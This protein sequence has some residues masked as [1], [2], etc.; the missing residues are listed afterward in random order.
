MGGHRPDAL[1]LGLRREQLRSWHRKPAL[2][3]VYRDYHRRL[4][5]L[6]P[7][8]RLL[9]VGA[10]I[11]H[12]RDSASE[13]KPVVSLDVVAIPGIDVNGDAHRLR[14]RDAVFDGIVM[15]DTLHHLERPARFLREAARVVRPGGRLVMIEPGLTPLS[16]RLFRSFHVEPIDLAVDPYASGPLSRRRAPF[17]ANQA[18]PTLMV[19]RNDAA[20][21]L[22]DVDSRLRLVHWEWLSLGRIH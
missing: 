18:I 7:Q 8:G 15:L 17:D 6:S 12:L 11:R 10:G 5:S 2:R 3:R 9:E 13:D 1:D 21:A 20:A 14:F 4:L 22:R 19:Q 16:H